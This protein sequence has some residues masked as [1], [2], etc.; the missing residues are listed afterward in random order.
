M[1]NEVRDVIGDHIITHLTGV[2]GIKRRYILG[3]ISPN[4]LT[5]GYAAVGVDLTQLYADATRGLVSDLLIVFLRAL[6]GV[7]TAWVA[8]EALIVK[9]ARALL[10]AARRIGGGDFTTRTGL[11]YG[12]G[13]LSQL[14]KSFDQMAG[15][16]GRK[17][18]ELQSA[19][20][21]LQKMQETLIHLLSVTPAILYRMH[22]LEQRVLW[23][24]P[25]L[26]PVLGYPEKKALEE[27]WW[28]RNVDQGDLERVLSERTDLIASGY[29]VQEYRFHTAKGTTIWIRDEM[30]LVNP[31]E[32]DGR[33]IVG[34]WIDVTEKRLAE[35]QIL[36]QLQ[37][38]T[39]LYVGAQRL[40]ESLETEVIGRELVRI[41]HKIFGVQLASIARPQK[42]G[43]VGIVSC[44]PEDHPYP[45]E[46]IARWNESL[47][48]QGPSRKALETA[49]PQVGNDILRDFQSYARGGLIDRYGFRGVAAIPPVS[50]AQSLGVLNL[51]SKTPNSSTQK[52][53]TP[54]RLWQLKPLRR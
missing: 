20:S 14:A 29:M 6:A 41:C 47:E 37:A 32:G 31:G 23:V 2:D 35:D 7:L 11:K 15:S 51:Y 40:A 19:F 21:S 13:E 1:L 44:F 48:G 4:G 39:C 42:D 52:R 33:E 36:R 26:T 18:E 27:G 8:G 38:L 25:N 34:A 24:S 16:L 10:V 17:H 45:K 22:P 3:D 46:V 49:F 12:P 50:R 28:K 30:R 9:K 53:S 5:V 43:M 54:S